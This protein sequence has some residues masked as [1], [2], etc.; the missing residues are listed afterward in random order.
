[1]KIQTRARGITLDAALKD[2][3]ERRV[4]YALGS[5]SA[6]VRRVEVLL[7]DDNGPRGGSDQRCQVRVTL[8]GLPAVQVTDVQAEMGVAIDRAAG[9]AG[10]TLARQLGRV[11]ERG[12]DRRWVRPDGL[13]TPE[14]V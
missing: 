5:L 7:S 4:E 8:E 10:R 6:V 2:R 14:G 3:V 11:R 12:V 13:T 1:M 9:R